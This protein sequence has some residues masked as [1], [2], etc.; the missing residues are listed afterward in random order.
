MTKRETEFVEQI[1]RSNY[2]AVLGWLSDGCD[3]SLWDYVQAYQRVRRTTH[4]RRMPS[5][6]AGRRSFM[7]HTSF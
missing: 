2:D 6:D 4:S 1:I 5:K 3:G 7:A